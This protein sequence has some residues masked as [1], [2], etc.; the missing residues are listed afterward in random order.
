VA[1]F[2]TLSYEAPQA[3]VQEILGNQVGRLACTL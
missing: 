2:D 3:I 1:A